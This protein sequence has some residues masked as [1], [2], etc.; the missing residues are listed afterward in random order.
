MRATLHRARTAKPCGSYRCKNTIMPGDLYVR[1]VAF[2]SE[3]CREEATTPLV[4]AECA[5]CVDGHGDWIRSR[6]GVPA[7]LGVKVVFD[8][9]SG[10]IV[11]LY[12]GS[13]HVRL[14]GGETVPVHPMWRMEY[15]AETVGAQ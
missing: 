1:H 2:P 13:V 12:G 7:R 6:Y 3:E 4:T 9:R 11:A 15:V 14:D 10:V 8:G 5:P